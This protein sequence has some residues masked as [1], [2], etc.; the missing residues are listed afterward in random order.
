MSCATADR[1]LVPP[2]IDLQAL[3]RELAALGAEARV[4]RALEVLPPRPILSSSFGAQAAVALHLLTRRLP[5]IPVVLIDTG[6]LFP[7]TYRFADALATRLDLDLRVYQAR[8]S[9]AWLEARHGR[10]WEQGAAGIRRYNQVHKV[11]PM[12]RALAELGAGAWFAGLRRRQSE[13]RAAIE[14]VHAIGDGRFKVHP[15]YDWTDRDVH[16]YL[17]RHGLPYHPLRDKGYVSI[18]DWHTTR[19]LHE[20]DET[21][22]ATRFFGLQRE[23]GLHLIGA[24]PGD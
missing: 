15:I 3:N 21:L 17:K 10:L 24:K 19:P 13:S 22:E 5:R 20:T 1:R 2:G 4:E 6:Y 14:P 9:A 16:E 8:H 7:E 12:Q 23:C 18:G 11:E